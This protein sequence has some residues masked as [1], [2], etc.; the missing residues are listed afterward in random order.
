MYTHIQRVVVINTNLSTTQW[1]NDKIT[2]V[3]LVSTNTG[4]GNSHLIMNF[5]AFPED[6]Q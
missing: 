6:N 2:M 5:Y 3:G 4:T 1:L